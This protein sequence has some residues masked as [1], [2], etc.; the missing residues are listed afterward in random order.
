MPAT[1]GLHL[2]QSGAFVLAS[3]PDGDPVGYLDDQLAGRVVLDSEHVAALERTWEAVRAE[4]LPRAHSRDLIR[5]L[6]DER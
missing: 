4:A 2:G 5:K 6:V 3:L 1:A